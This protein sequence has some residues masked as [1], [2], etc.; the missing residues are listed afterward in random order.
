ME[1][2]RPAS[3]S[4]QACVAVREGSGAANPL[5]F[6]QV[7]ARIEVGLGA[8]AGR[9]AIVRVPNITKVF[10]GRDVGYDIERIDLPRDVE[11]VSATRLRQALEIG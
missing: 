10:Y 3:A 9:F 11:R 1:S 2:R 4:R 7:A 8:H 5:P 6:E